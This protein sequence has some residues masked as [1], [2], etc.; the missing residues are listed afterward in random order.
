MNLS[1][2]LGSVT[3]IIPTLVSTVPLTLRRPLLNVSTVFRISLLGPVTLTATLSFDPISVAS[4][5]RS[6]VILTPS[7]TGGIGANFMMAVVHVGPP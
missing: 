3:V 4:V 7:M 6:I 5:D 2:F 1:L